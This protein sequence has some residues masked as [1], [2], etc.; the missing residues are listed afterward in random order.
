LPNDIIEE[1]AF[2]CIGFIFES[3]DSTIDE[4]VPVPVSMMAAKNSDQSGLGHHNG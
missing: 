3:M 1:I 2:E 4:Q